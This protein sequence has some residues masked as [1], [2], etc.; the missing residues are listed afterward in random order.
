MCQMFDTVYKK[1]YYN[2]SKM[3]ETFIINGNRELA[4]EIEVRGSKNAA[5]PCLVASLLTEEDCV[6]DNLPLIEDINVTLEI[7]KDLGVTVEFLSERKIKLNAKNLNIENM[8]FEKFAKSRI[9]VL[10][11][12]PLITRFKQ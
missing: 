3:T 11:L 8:D 7:L 6:I 5:G 9:S 12:G 2:L 10:F 1:E 4:G